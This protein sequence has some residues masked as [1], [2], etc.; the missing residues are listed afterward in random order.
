[1]VQGKKEGGEGE[2]E[3]V[4]GACVGKRAAADEVVPDLWVVGVLGPGG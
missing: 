4:G 2:R 1:M 3:V